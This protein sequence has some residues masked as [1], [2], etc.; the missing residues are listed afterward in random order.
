LSSLPWLL[1]VETKLL[2]VML[3]LPNA[4]L[5]F[6]TLIFGLRDWR[7]NRGT[8]GFTRQ[9]APSGINVKEKEAARPNTLLFRT[10]RV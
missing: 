4:A 8:H 2:F 6:G 3:A 9:A 1:S 5:L 10:D 7:I